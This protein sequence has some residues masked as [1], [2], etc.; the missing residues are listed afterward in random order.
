MP[1]AYL[2]GMIQA[3]E[4]TDLQRLEIYLGCHYMEKLSLASISSALGISHFRK[5]HRRDMKN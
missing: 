5:L 1:V 4:Y 3:T 2:A